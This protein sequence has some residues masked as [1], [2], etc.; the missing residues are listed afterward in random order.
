MLA[1]LNV[2]AAAGVAATNNLGIWAVDTTAR[3][4]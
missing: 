1:T 2:N 4:N 3:S